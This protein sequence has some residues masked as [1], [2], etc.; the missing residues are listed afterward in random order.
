MRRYK[1]VP[2]ERF[3]SLNELRCLGFVPDGGKHRDVVGNGFSNLGECAMLEDDRA[4]LWLKLNDCTRS[5]G[6]ESESGAGVP[7]GCLDL[8]WL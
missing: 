1:T 6:A 3:L 5:D 2:R 4:S 7:E 8:N